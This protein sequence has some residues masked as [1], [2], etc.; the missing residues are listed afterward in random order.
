MPI[1]ASK[2]RFA[3]TPPAALLAA[4]ADNGIPVAVSLL[5]IVGGDLE[6]DGFVMH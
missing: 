6:R 2:A 3:S 1:I 4:I 5:L